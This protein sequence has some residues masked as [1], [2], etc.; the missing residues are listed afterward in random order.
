MML[1]LS[2]IMDIIWMI[3]VLPAWSQDEATNPDWKSLSTVHSLTGFFSF[4]EILVKGAMI[5]LAFRRGALQD[6]K[7]IND[8]AYNTK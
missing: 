5:F 7:F 1:S 8:G 2:V 6:L 4:L 3:L